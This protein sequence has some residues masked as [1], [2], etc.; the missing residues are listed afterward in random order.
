[1]KEVYEKN[2]LEKGIKEL[3]LKMGIATKV[4]P[5][6]GEKISIDGIN[7]FNSIVGIKVLSHDIEIGTYLFDKKTLYTNHKA[8]HNICIAKDQV[9]LINNFVGYEKYHIKNNIL[10][11][12][13]K[14]KDEVDP[15]CNMSDYEI[16]CMF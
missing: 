10:V 16:A 11:A 14:F 3:K 15:N 1:M 2:M 5:V 8:S 6:F 7:Y 4:V 13:E 9:D 12:F